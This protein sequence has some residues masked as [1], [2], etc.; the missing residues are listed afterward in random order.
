M[1]DAFFAVT[2]T[3]VLDPAENER[4]R[5]RRHIFLARY[6]RQSM[7]QWGEVEGREVRRYADALAEFLREENEAMK[8]ATAEAAMRDTR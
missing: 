8:K 1:I 4:Q 6:G 5:L 7:L 3:Q 2:L